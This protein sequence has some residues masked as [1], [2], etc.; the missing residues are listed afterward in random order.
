MDSS[1]VVSGIKGMPDYGPDMCYLKR[2]TID[3]IIKIFHVYGGKE[4]DTPVLERQQTIKN[5]Y[6]EEFNKLVFKVDNKILRYDLTVPMARYMGTKGLSAYKR[7]QIGKVYRKDNPEISKGRLCEFTQIDFDI[8]NENTH[9]MTQ[10]IEILNL[11]CDVLDKFIPNKYYIRLNFREFLYNIMEK[12][13]ITDINT[14]CS[15][16]DKLD[17]V[18][19]IDIMNDLKTKFPE[20][21]IDELF[22]YLGKS[23]EELRD[24]NI[25]TNYEQIKSFLDTLSNLPIKFDLSLAR[26]LDYYTGIIYEVSYID[27][28]SSIAAGGR[29]DNLIGN[30]SNYPT[31]AIGFSIGLD[32]LMLYLENDYV[33][34]S[35]LVY[36]GS[37]G[38]NMDFHRMKI[39][40]ELRKNNI[41]AETFYKSNLKMRQQLNEVFNK[42]IQYM[43]IVGEN[44]VKNNIVKFKDIN[45]KKQ[46]DVTIED[47]IL[48]LNK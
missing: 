11:L 15:S 23:L 27:G 17:K 39:V 32:R 20:N 42:K 7:Y 41:Y 28:G 10:E 3:E 34:Q 6:G 13:N 46:I 22:D 2:K 29:Y 30:L 45:A 24:D 16:I 21:I 43:V 38:D 36:V 37:V 9:N 31:G 25:I 18:P 19:K 47:L 5:I 40:L 44:E 26:G 12:L 4:I 14:V 48:I 35:P 33:E 8:I 1:K